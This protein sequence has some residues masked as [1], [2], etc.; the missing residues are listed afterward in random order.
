MAERESSE[1]G[2]SVLETA[3]L[4]V[5][6][7]AARP[8]RTGRG[9]ETAPS[10]IDKRPVTES[11]RIGPL[12]LDGDEQADLRVHGGADKAVYVYSQ[13]HL[14]H[15]R[16]VLGV[17]ALGPGAFG[18]NLSVAALEEAAVHVGD[19]F[20][21]GE[22]LLEVSQPREPCWKLG[23]HL[24]NASLPKRVVAS[25]RVGF[26]L[27]VIEPG[28][29]R[30]GDSMRRVHVDA[31]RLSIAEVHRTRHFGRGDVAA[32]RRA[33]ENAALSEA[34]RIALSKRLGEVP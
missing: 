17:A 26:Y 8:L 27:R 32:T 29:V 11:V 13:H 9:D 16:E 28:I 20:R 23:A 3:L 7:G 5:N 14:A 4:A 18:E 2:G 19:R 33:L 6:T 24:G 15:W 25:G 1:G 34:W 31:G 10:G 30:A 21:A 22:A 12:G